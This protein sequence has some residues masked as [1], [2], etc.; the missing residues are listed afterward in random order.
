MRCYDTFLGDA[1]SCALQ[2]IRARGSAGADGLQFKRGQWPPVAP[3][4][5]IDGS[6]LAVLPE[7]VVPVTAY[8]KVVVHCYLQPLGNPHQLGRDQLVVL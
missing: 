6:Y 8:D 1:G 4:G 3:C 5:I 7:A 2:L